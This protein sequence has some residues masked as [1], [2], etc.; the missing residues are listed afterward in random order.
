MKANNIL[1]HKI[2]KDTEFFRYKIRD[3]FYK[4]PNIGFILKIWDFDFSCIKDDIKNHKVNM[5]WTKKSMLF[6]NK[7]DIM[8]SIIFSVH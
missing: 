6:M 3:K 5:N 7:I 1:I 8:I 4:V 2:S